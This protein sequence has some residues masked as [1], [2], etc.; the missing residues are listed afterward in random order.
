MRWIV[1]PSNPSI[2]ET[3]SRSVSLGPAVLSTCMILSQ[4]AILSIT[5]FR[6]AILQTVDLPSPR[7]SMYWIY[8][9]N[10]ERKGT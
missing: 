3:I 1:E 9:Y 10:L 4:Q 5:T 7:L 2:R 6:S 8:E